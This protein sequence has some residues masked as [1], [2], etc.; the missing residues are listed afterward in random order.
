MLDE[1]AHNCEVH[2]LHRHRAY[3]RRPREERERAYPGRSTSLS[4]VTGGFRKEPY[5]GV[6]VSSGHSSRKVKAQTEPPQGAGWPRS[7]SNT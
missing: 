6:E 1:Q 5:H 3:I 4:E 2:I 7:L